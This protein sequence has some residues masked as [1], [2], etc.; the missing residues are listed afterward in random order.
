MKIDNKQKAS[1]IRVL[2][3][4]FPLLVVAGTALFFLLSDK[5]NIWYILYALL[6]L[7][8]YF[9]IMSFFRF[10]YVSFYAG[11]D[12]VRVRHK[13]LAPFKSANKSIQIKADSFHS[14]E[15]VKTKKGKFKTLYLFQKSPGGVAKYPG[16]SLTAVRRADAEKMIKALQLI[17]AMKKAQTN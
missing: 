1:R 16:I 15:L 2:Y 4:I 8:A 5:V 13:S 11:P 10:N 14:F 3:L 17:L 6:M 7:L 9:I 12:Q